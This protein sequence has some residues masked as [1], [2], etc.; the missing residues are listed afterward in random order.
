[1]EKIRGAEAVVEI[2][3]SRVV[4]KRTGKSY[5]HPGI[6]ARLREERSSR[7]ENNLRA[8]R[9]SDV[10]VPDVLEREGGRL[11]LE[12]IEGPPL[13]QVLDDRLELV[14]PLGSSVAKLHSAGILHGDLTTSN[15][16]A[17]GEG[18]VLIDFGLSYRSERTEDRAMDLHLFRQ[19]LRSSH[20]EVEREAWR[21]F[22]EGYRS[23]EFS[24]EVLDRLE[25][26]EKRG[27]YK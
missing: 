11:V 20:P 23:G 7:E 17:S 9:R 14:E 18:P 26:V 8:A 3:G 25:E 16:V 4:K 5:R 24:A 15:V 13:K 6:D 21:R 19:T 12:R 22:E 27:R 1:M 2:E 10:P